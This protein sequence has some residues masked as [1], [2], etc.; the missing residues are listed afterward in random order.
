MEA[1]CKEKE[2]SLIVEAHIN[3]TN[4]VEKCMYFVW[5]IYGKGRT[6]N[7]LSVEQTYISSLSSVLMFGEQ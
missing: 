4:L 7:R 3:Q 1:L 5:N 6:T 2:K